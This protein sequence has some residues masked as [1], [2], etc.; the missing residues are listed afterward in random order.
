MVGGLDGWLVAGHLTD[1]ANFENFSKL[2]TAV[3]PSN[4]AP[5]GLKLW[6]N[7]FQMIPDIWIFDARNFFLMKFSDRK[8]SIKSEIVR[9]GGATNFWALPA[10]S[11]RKITPDV[12]NFKSLRFLVRGFKDDF[13][14]FRWLLAQNWLT[15]FLRGWW[16]DDLMIWWYDD[17]MMIK[18]FCGAVY[19]FI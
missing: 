8:W 19:V 1:F 16:Y 17:R 5:F 15:V 4:M 7:A 2:R 18:S 14:F 6:Q 10:D 3:Y 12:P 11:P 13:R 9:F